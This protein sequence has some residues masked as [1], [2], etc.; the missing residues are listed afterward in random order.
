M[1]IR[2]GEVMM[3]LSTLLQTI[4][5]QEREGY[6]A[7]RESVQEEVTTLQSLSRELE[8]DF[9]PVSGGLGRG[10]DRTR[11]ARRARQILS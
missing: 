7:L 4:V 8:M 1:E 11:T 3:H 5:A 2:G 6:E 9:C 10:R